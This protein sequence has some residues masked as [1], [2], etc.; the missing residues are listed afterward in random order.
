[1]LVN[2][3]KIIISDPHSMVDASIKIS[4]AGM[5]PQETV[6]FHLIKKINEERYLASQASFVA[7]P[8][9]KVELDH[10]AP[11]HGTYCG[12]DG[13][14][15]FW[16]MEPTVKN[17][18]TH[19][20]DEK[21]NQ[22]DT[23]DELSPQTSL[24]LLETHDEIVA[25]QAVTRHWTSNDTVKQ[26][27]RE[28]GLIGNFFYN[29][30]LKPRPGI[31]VVGGS[32][33][34]MNEKTAALLASHGFSVFALAYFGV[35]NLQKQLRDIPLEYVESAIKWLQKRSEVQAGGFGIHGTSRGSELAL[36]SAALFPEI[37]A[38]VS[39]NGSAVSFSGIVPW[40]NDP[41]LP[42]AWT[43]QGQPL[44][45]LQPDNPVQLANECKE[46]WISQ[47][48]NPFRKWHDGLS[49]N[50]DWLERAT[51]PLE[52]I[53]GEVLMISG[54]ADESWDSAA[55][56]EQG[57]RRK[58][59]N[60]PAAISK[61]LIYDGAGHYIGIPYLRAISPDPGTKQQ[62]AEASVDSWKKTIEFFKQRLCT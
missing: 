7:D 28:A 54:S 23:R 62:L 46:M 55:L 11:I 9:G 19:V 40:S 29:K 24:M 33:G 35:E 10:Q 44:P 61:H 16:S 41:T 60:D 3:S 37:T 38:V 1:M 12:V 22:P 13:M 25:H 5:Q 6:T 8:E 58:T 18:L 49:A 2:R 51:I 17:A 26:T 32:E 45:Y 31:I 53:N 57:L 20:L 14:A 4:A 50:I 34:G 36:W 59:Q 43:Y 56:S 27:V 47:K 30:D 42:P 15:L 52:K 21:Y 39:L 48:G